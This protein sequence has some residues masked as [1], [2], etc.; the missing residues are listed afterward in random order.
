MTILKGKKLTKNT[1]IKEG[2][3][4]DGANFSSFF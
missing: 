1:S 3:L 4:S 2:E